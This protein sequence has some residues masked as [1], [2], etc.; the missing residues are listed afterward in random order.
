MNGGLQGANDCCCGEGD[1]SDRKG[2]EQELAAALDLEGE[3]DPRGRRAGVPGNG[4]SLCGG[5]K[6]ATSVESPTAHPE[7][8]D[9]PCLFRRTS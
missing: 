3:S 1:G 2:F 9:C 5:M 8:A 6:C 4:D 7:H